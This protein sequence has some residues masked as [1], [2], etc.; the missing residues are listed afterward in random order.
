MLD[1]VF[2]AP[3]LD[4]W[5][6]H[7]PLHRITALINRASLEALAG[8]SSPLT[9]ELSEPRETEPG[10]RTGPLDPRFLGL[11][12]TRACNLACVYCGFAA[13][14]DSG[15]MDPR[16]ACAAVDWMAD[17]AARAGHQTLDVHFFGGEP[18]AAPEVVRAAVRHTRARAAERGLVPRLGVA[19]NGAYDETCATFVGDSFDDVALSF[20]GFAA[21]HNRHR[22]L[23]PGRGSFE[24]VSRTARLLSRSRA[25]L[26]LRMCVAHDNVE[27]LPAAVEWFCTEFRPSSVDLETLRPTPESERAG[28]F[29]PDPYLFAERLLQASQVAIG[30]GVVP[31]YAA[32]AAEPPRI[33]RCPVGDDTLIVHP[34]GTVSPCYLLERDWRT[35][36]LDLNLGRRDLNGT[37]R[38]DREA[39]ERVRRLPA[40]KP[41]CEGCFCRWSCAGGCH[42][43]HS[44]PGCSRRYDGFCVQTRLITACSLLARLNQA[45]LAAALLADGPA[46]ERLA[47]WPD[48]RLEHGTATC[49]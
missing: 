43:N 3:V 25:A 29:P 49:L 34:D 18:L 24:Q 47:L 22:P 10:P 1:R 12:P 45:P 48:D 44:F 7:A 14:P 27:D 39:V 23:R 15:Q 35:R 26:C 37:L 21:V 4:R 42:V 5:L 16:L 19:T 31:V 28:L 33:T 9:P 40:A 20:D 2:A 36:G 30:R 38:L 13:A 46:R 8:G 6:I 41:R 17:R 11:V 32:A